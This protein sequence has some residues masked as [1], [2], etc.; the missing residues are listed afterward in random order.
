V[1]LACAAAEWRAEVT[2]RELVAAGDEYIPTEPRVVR[3]GG[4][5]PPK[6]LE[7]LAGSG[8]LTYSGTVSVG[9]T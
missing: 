1:L 5:V 3:Q 7:E 2:E 8:L 9:T 6:L 4:R